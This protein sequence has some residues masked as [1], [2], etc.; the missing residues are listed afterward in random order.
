MEVS[1]FMDLM[2]S[3]RSP[4]IPPDYEQI[5]A[6]TAQVCAARSVCADLKLYNYEEALEVD[7]AVGK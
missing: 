4:M 3:G 1:G 2:K 6:V 5:G 7:A